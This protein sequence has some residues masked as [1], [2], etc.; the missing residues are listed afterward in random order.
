M[1]F[2]WGGTEGGFLIRKIEDGQSS[3]S[4]PINIYEWSKLNN[5][6]VLVLNVLFI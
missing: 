4:K 1:N 6:P 5:I 2:F 3:Y